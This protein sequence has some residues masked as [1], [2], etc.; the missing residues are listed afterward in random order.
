MPTARFGLITE[1]VGGKIYALSVKA[2]KIA[3]KVFQDVAVK[4]KKTKHG[5]L[6]EFVAPTKTDIALLELTSG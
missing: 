5:R 6:I 4:F 2:D 1:E 3:G